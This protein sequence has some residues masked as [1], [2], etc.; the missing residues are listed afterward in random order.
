MIAGSLF[1]CVVVCILNIYELYQHNQK[2]ERHWPDISDQKHWDMRLKFK[3][4]L[5][6][7]ILLLIAL[8]G[9]FIGELIKEI[10]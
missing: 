1:A 9:L 7:E 4:G 6:G 2:V 8:I 3:V 5:G 10:F